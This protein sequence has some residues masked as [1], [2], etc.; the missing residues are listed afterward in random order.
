MIN[1]ESELS[2]GA[3]VAYVQMQGRL[4]KGE[5]EID[6]VKESIRENWKRLRRLAAAGSG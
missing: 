1:I 5:I 6:R 3:L 4:G 2:D